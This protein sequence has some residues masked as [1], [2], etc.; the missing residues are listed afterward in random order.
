MQNQKAIV[1]P[2]D[3]QQI[4]LFSDSEQSNR[5]GCVF[6]FND[7]DLQDDIKCDT[8]FEGKIKVRFNEET[9]NDS[10]K[11]FLL[12][13]GAVDIDED[14]E[15]NENEDDDYEKSLWRNNW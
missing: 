2:F 3:A 7:I 14:E 9:S 15:F 1:M 10:N 8:F 4:T 12:G 11:N 13:L 6:V 5:L